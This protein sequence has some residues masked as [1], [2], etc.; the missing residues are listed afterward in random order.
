MGAR[1]VVC[2]VRDPAR[3]AV[4]YAGAE[5]AGI[6]RSADYSPRSEAEWGGGA[7][8]QSWARGL[9]GASVYTLAFD[10]L[11]RT[12]LYAA[13]DRGAFVLETWTP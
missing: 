7:T 3:P 4:L 11:G 12:R 1:S 13:T 5:G 2:L 6:Y 8:W 9:E 10:P